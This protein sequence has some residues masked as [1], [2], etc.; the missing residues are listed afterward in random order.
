MGGF[1][2]VQKAIEERRAY[3]ILEKVEITDEIL[4]KLTKAVQLAPSC[5]NNQP[6]RFLF[7]RK[8]DR[9]EEFKQVLAKGNDWA[10][11]ASMMAVIFSKKEDDCVVHDRKYYLFDTGIAVGQMLLQATELGLVAHPI[12][13]FSPKKVRKLTG[14]SQDYKI[15][16]MIIFGK[17]PEKAEE[18]E[19]PPRKEFNEI[20]YLDYYNEKE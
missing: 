6:W 8:Q 13:G 12:A 19:R 16:T 5:Y 1:M 7:V 18:E 20:R 9:L 14:I 2:Q 4:D 17:H 3:R 11:D 15:I 10:F